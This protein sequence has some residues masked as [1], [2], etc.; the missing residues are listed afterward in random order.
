MD[1]SEA[2]RLAAEA[3]KERRWA[4]AL[5]HLDD[6]TAWRGKFGFEPVTPSGVKGD[7]FASQVRRAC[8]FRRVALVPAF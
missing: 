1:P 4:G 2:L 3:A 5:S 8:Y 6:Y 7:E